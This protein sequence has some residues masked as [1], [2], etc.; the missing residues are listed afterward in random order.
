MQNWYYMVKGMS[1]ICN[2]GL[3]QI[4]WPVS[5]DNNTALDSC[6]L[7][8]ATATRP[9]PLATGDFPT[10]AVIAEAWNKL[11]NADYFHKNRMHG[12]HT[13][14]DEDIQTLLHV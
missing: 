7:L 10:A 2:R 13:F 5:A 4:P 9:T 1:A 12:L 11:G 8:M 14:Q 6:D 3:L